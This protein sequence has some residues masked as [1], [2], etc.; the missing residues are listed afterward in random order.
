MRKRS[1]TVPEERQVLHFVQDDKGT[2]VCVVL[3]CLPAPS[4]PSIK[5][6]I[7]RRI[8]SVKESQFP[9]HVPELFLEVIDFLP[10]L[11]VPI[12]QMLSN[13]VDPY[14]IQYSYH[15][16]L[17]LVATTD[18]PSGCRSHKRYDGN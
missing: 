16:G 7:L 9:L 3:T 2:E 4:L 12:H 10:L 15:D 11:V 6:M 14:H 17:C 5:A 13:S 1:G 18:V 8:E